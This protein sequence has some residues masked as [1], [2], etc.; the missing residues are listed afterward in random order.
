VRRHRPADEKH[1]NGGP[2]GLGTAEALKGWMDTA[3]VF[4][5][6]LPPKG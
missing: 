3:L 1:G 2:A 6:T 5:E 4:V